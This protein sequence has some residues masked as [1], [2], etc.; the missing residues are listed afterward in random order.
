MET[1]IFTALFG[2]GLMLG[3]IGIALIWTPAYVLLHL[4]ELKQVEEPELERRF[5][6]SYLEYKRRVPMFIP[7]L[8]GSRKQDLPSGS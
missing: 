4:I 1:G 7:R 8:R 6:S 5:G 3:S 2:I